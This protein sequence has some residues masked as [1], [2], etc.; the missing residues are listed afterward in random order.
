L[1]SG[2]LTSSAMA[3]EVRAR[4]ANPTTRRMGPCSCKPRSPEE[5]RVAAVDDPTLYALNFQ[6]FSQFHC[7]RAFTG[8]PHPHTAGVFKTILVPQTSPKRGCAY[9]LAVPE[10]PPN[11]MLTYGPI[12]PSAA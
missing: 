10:T 9:D 12:R 1:G 7:G 4:T 11:N 6:D 5:K 2:A 8:G 3:T